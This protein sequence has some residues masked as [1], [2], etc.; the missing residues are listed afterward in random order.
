MFRIGLE[1]HSRIA[2]KT[3]LFSNAENF[4]YKANAAV[5]SCVSHFD[6]G[7]PGILPLLN[8]ECLEKAIRAGLLLNC[9]ISDAVLFDRK[10]Y[11]Y[12][13]MP[14]GY[15]ITQKRLPIA[16]AGEFNSIPIK[17]IQLENDTAKM[18]RQ[19]HESSFEMDFNRSGLGLLEIVTAPSFQSVKE[20]V[21]FASQ[22]NQ[23]LVLNDIADEHVESGSFRVDANINFF[24][25]RTGMQLP[26]VEVKN[27]MGFSFLE[28][29][30][31]YEVNRQLALI[32]ARK[33]QEIQKETRMFCQKKLK[34]F[35]IRSKKDYIF[36]PEFDLPHNISTKRFLQKASEMNK[37]YSQAFTE[38]PS[39]HRNYLFN[40]STSKQLYLAY[41][42]TFTNNEPASEKAIKFI[43][44]ELARAKVSTQ[45]D[46]LCQLVKAFDQGIISTKAAS[47]ILSKMDTEDLSIDQFIA[48]YD[49]K[50]V[51][52]ANQVKQ[53]VDLFK[54]THSKHDIATFASLTLGKYDLSEAKRHFIQNRHDRD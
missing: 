31:E 19:I 11:H 36:V 1:C 51:S 24:S 22:L 5:N 37:F 27:V 26:V 44:N 29:A 8:E 47:F 41:R 43:C 2:S 30:L 53:A 34:T 32:H 6:L 3:K 33:E 9:R 45:T 42:R 20:A 38:V 28:K 13:D 40:S 48:K 14:S 4:V 52:D 10:H 7:F 21:S 25:T 35:P 50:F 23:L 54:K 16:S 18:L 12:K 15:Q 39:K 49:L 46:K 17:A